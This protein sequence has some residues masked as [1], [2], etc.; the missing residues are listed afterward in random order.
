MVPKSDDIYLVIIISYWIFIT[1]KSHNETGPVKL[2]FLRSEKKVFNA[3]NNFIL[4]ACIFW[5]N[6]LS[7]VVLFFDL[8]EKL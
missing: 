6:A 2:H 7:I 8:F 3:K 4:S 5:E 1:Q